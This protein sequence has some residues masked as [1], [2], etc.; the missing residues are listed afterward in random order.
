MDYRKGFGPQTGG[1]NRGRGNRG[2]RG[3]P[4]N[5][6]WLELVPIPRTRGNPFGFD[7]VPSDRRVPLAHDHPL[8]LE[9]ASMR[10]ELDLRN[11]YWTGME[12]DIPDEM[13]NS[14]SYDFQMRRNEMQEYDDKI[15][16]ILQRIEL[17]EQGIAPAGP[18]VTISFRS[19]GRSQQ[20]GA[21]P[22]YARSA[23][24]P[25]QR[26]QDKNQN[27]KRNRKEQS[28]VLR[29]GPERETSNL[30]S[31]RHSSQPISHANHQ[32]QLSS[33][34]YVEFCGL[35]MHRQRPWIIFIVKWNLM[36]EVAIQT[37]NLRVHT[38]LCSSEATTIHHHPPSH[39]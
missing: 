30:Y 32:A 21:E 37:Q 14:G 29:S 6:P 9:L 26:R 25:V 24:N 15:S 16:D 22:S 31:T 28:V 39:P 19:A 17:A 18:P 35:W 2:R 38:H 33:H 10:H 7:T 27:R 1:A 34:Q 23:M 3:R 11:I 8:N 20:P 36:V 13:A 5:R 4:D 12:Q